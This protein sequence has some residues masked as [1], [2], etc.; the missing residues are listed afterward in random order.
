MR[1][2]RN[3]QRKI[4]GLGVAFDGWSHDRAELPPYFRVIGGRSKFEL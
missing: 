1:S 4:Y 2:E 3:F